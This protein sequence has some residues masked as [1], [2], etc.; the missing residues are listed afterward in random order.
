[1][2]S[3]NTVT[4]SDIHTVQSL[5]LEVHRL[6]LRISI[7]LEQISQ[8]PGILN[9]SLPSEEIESSLRKALILKR[10]LDIDLELFNHLK[11]QLRQRGYTW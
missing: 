9:P 8:L 3:G 11:D 1:M 7:L 4:E 2:R 10:K 6:R 5:L